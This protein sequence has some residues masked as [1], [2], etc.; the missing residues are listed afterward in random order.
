[1]KK[2]VM[3][4]VFLL[5][6]ALTAAPAAV[7]WLLHE[8]L[9]QWADENSGQVQVNQQRGWRRSSAHLAGDGYALELRFRHLTLKPAS[10]LAFAGMGRLD[11]VE[12]TFDLHGHVT[13]NGTLHVEAA[14]SALEWPGDVVWRYQEPRLH[15]VISPGGDAAV[16]ARASSAVGLDGLGNQLLLEQARLD[17]CL[18]TE[19]SSADASLDVQAQRMARP[20]SRLQL[21][22]T[23][24]DREAAGEA[25]AQLRLLLAARPESPAQAMALIGVLNGWQQMVERGLR[26][27]QAV[28]QLDG[29]FQ[30]EAAWQPGEKGF[31][32]S[33]GGSRR[34][35]ADWWAG[36][37]GLSQ[38]VP[39]G[40]ARREIDLRLQELADQDW[41]HLERDRIELAPAR[42]LPDS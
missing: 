35:L 2:F 20:D 14:A 38:Q 31:R 36:I 13:G 7:G 11:T 32:L 25:L 33:G 3:V 21:S 23:G 16:G 5:L 27:E 15:L 24:V 37:H 19:G 40:T 9:A 17:F 26:L 30:V 6:L 29:D 4:L 34:A 12:A 8:R 10:L 39:P 18:Q 42:Q 22:L 41:L 28:L 1:M